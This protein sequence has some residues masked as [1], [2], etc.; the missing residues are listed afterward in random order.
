MAT[1]KSEPR[2]GIIVQIAVILVVGV[3]VA[4]FGLASYFKAMLH[5]EE[6]KKVA[7]IGA[8]EFSKRRQAERAA[9]DS[10]SLDKG[11][12][13]LGKPDRGPLAA[14]STKDLGPLEGWSQA[15]M[16]A[17]PFRVIEPVVEAGTGAEVVTDGGADARPTDAATDA[18]P[19]GQGPDAAKRLP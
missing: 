10:V 3:I 18:K 9:L 14:T 19:T 4:R 11:A 2:I 1:D 12:A 6:Q 15:P 16:D 7:T 8:E 13:L 17:G 5:K